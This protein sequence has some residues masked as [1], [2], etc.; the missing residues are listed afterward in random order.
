MS[1]DAIGD[2]RE[3]VCRLGRGQALVEA[4]TPCGALVRP[5]SPR[6][7]LDGVDVEF[8]PGDLRDAESV[9]QAIAGRLTFFTSRPTTDCGRAIA[10]DRRGECRRTRTIMTEALRAGVERIVYTSSVAT[11]APRRD[12]APVDE[13]ASARGANAIGAYKR[14]KVAAERMVQAMIAN[15][16]LPAVI[17]NPSTPLDR[18]TCAQR[19]PAAWCRGG[20]GRIPVS[21]IPPQPRACRRCRRRHLARCIKVAWRA[22]HPR[23]RERAVLATPG[24]HCRDRRAVA[25]ALAI[26]S[27]RVHAARL[28]REGVARLT[29]REPFVTRD[30]LRMAKYRMFFSAAKAER[31]LGLSRPAVPRRAAHA[32]DW[33]RKAGYLK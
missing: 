5:T 25:A 2:R 28:R 20:G 10:R 9:R 32:I 23:R 12:G 24:R 26:S 8:V 29:G 31:E 30:G 14:S 1:G 6:A 15:E 17:V 19:R 27:P 33:F 7:H 16:G 11:L 18:A 3:R 4:A 21:S 13:N 22:L